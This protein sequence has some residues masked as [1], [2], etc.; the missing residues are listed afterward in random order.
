MKSNRIHYFVVAGY[1]DHEGIIRL[2]D[3]PSVADAVL[4]GTLYDEESNEWLT[5]ATDDEVQRDE[6]ILGELRKRLGCVE[7]VTA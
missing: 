4:D 2:G 3:D 1:V 5:C 6:I 7:A